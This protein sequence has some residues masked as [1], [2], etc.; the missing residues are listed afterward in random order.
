MDY[1]KFWL[2]NSR[3][4]RYNFTEDIHIFLNA[5]T[6]L[7]FTRNYD[8]LKVGNSELVTSQE[9]ALTDVAGEL[10]F[11]QE[12]N[13]LK[14]QAYQDFIRFIKFKPLELHYLTPN[15][16]GSYHCDVLITAV[17][18][19]E[20]GSDTGY[21]SVPIT[22]HRLT[23][24]LTDEDEVYDLNNKPL[25]DG[26]YYDRH[27]EYNYAGTNL[28]NTVITNDGTDDVGFVIEV[29][30]EI[31][32]MQFTLTQNGKVYGICKING[33]YDYI[34]IDSVER[35]ETIYLENNGSAIA[36]PEQYQD[37]TIANNESYLTWCKLKVGETQF[38][39]SG[40]NIDTF[41]GN[42]VIRF[43]PSYATV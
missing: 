38:A 9:F 43:K 19:S 15:N 21:L 22:M 28:S 4:E 10:L 8:Y 1:R 29:T 7:G 35:T 41:D 17:D 30:G 32:N 40:G 23:E 39:M 14:Y 25:G 24:W 13:G 27:Y 36:N 20:V 31:Q 5:P 11:L 6:G 37:F 18:K 3:G 42:V 2:I 12:T 34:M 26:K 33:T 16:V